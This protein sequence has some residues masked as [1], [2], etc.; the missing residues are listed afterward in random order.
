MLVPSDKAGDAVYHCPLNLLDWSM[1]GVDFFLVPTRQSGN[2]VGNTP[3]LRELDA[4]ASARHS[5]VND[6]I[7]GFSREVSS[8]QSRRK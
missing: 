6:S 2:A 5:Y 7:R 8:P 3:A 4:G 1:N